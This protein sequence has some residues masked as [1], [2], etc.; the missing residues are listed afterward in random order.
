MNRILVLALFLSASPLYSANLLSVNPAALDFGKIGQGTTKTL[1]VRLKTSGALAVGIVFTVSSPFQIDRKRFSMD[2][3]SFNE[4]AVTVPSSL[5]LGD[6][7][8]TLSLQVTP[9]GIQDSGSE[10]IDVPLHALVR[11]VL[12]DFSAEAQIESC[13]REGKFM[14]CSVKVSVTSTA[15]ASVDVHTVISRW[16]N[17]K[18]DETSVLDQVLQVSP[19]SVIACEVSKLPVKTKQFNLRISLDPENKIE[20]EDEDNNTKE[21]VL[22]IPDSSIKN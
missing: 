3:L 10:K 21:V 18:K 17:D 2:K 6:Y 1:K 4:V 13:K 16:I 8:G 11:P 14:T 22:D 20:E 5:S 7:N 9:I 19:K 12:P 15:A